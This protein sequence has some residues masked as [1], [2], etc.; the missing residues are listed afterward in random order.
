MKTVKEVSKI[1]GISI[2][3]LR[4]YDEIGLLK[5]SKLSSTGYRLYDN[6]S[7]E[8]LQEIMF[9]RELEI[10]LHD[11]KKIMDNPNYDKKQA[12]LSQLALL[13]HKRNRLNGIIELIKDVLEGVNTMSF[14]AFN[15][16]DIKKIIEIMRSDLSEEDFQAFIKE[17]GGGNIEKYEEILLKSLTDG[18][19]SSDILRWYRSKENFIKASKPQH[20]TGQT[21][22]DIHEIYIGFATLMNSPDIESEHLLVERLANSYKNMLKF[23]NPRAFLLD[24]AKEFQNEKLADIHDT[25]YGKGSSKYMAEAI[26]RYY[27]V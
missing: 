26:Q 14:E 23:D 5:P 18:K 21:K 3:A 15:E 13:E 16:Q 12:L 10:P 4:Y 1:T 24:F 11:I 7:L 8:K 22:N 20:S 25:Q 9:Y 2:R 17:H 27:G 6:K 19:V